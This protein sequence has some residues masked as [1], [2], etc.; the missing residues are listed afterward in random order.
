MLNTLSDCRYIIF[1]LHHHYIK[2]GRVLTVLSLLAG[3]LSAIAVFL[4][5]T[6]SMIEQ[7]S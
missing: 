5:D 7:T 1:I 3:V 6:M 2:T 4:N